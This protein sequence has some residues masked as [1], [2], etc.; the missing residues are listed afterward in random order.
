MSVPAVPRLEVAGIGKTF[1]PARVLSAA[2]LVV[3]P[4]Q[5]HALV[6]QN[7]SGKS[8]LVKI[9][10]GYHSPDGGGAIR[11]DGGPLRLPVRWAEAHAAGISVVHQEL[12]LLDH[13]TV[14]ENI[15]VGGYSRTRYL[16]RIDWS[17]QRTVAADALRS[18]RLDIDPAALVGTLSAAQRAAVAIARAI[19]DLVP[20][21]GLVILDESTRSLGREELRQFHQML[22]RIMDTGTSVL[23]VSHNLDEV[24]TF[25]DRVTVL[26]DG[27]VVGQGLVTAEQTEQ[28]IAKLMLGKDVDRV[29]ARPTGTRPASAAS[30]AGLYGPGAAGLDI[31]VGAGEVVGLTG[32]PG[33]GFENIPYLLAGA[34]PAR[35]G[36]LAVG[37]AVVNLATG[38]VAAC[39][40]AGVALVPER[41]DRDGLAM[42]LSIRDNISLPGLRGGGRRYWVGRR[43]QQRQTAE[44]IERLGIK[45]NAPMR[46]VSE[47]SGGNQQ[48]V[49][50]AKWMT[51]GPKLMI[52]HE[53]T[54]A[55]DVGARSDILTAVH[56][57][58]DAGVSVLLVSV[59]AADLAAACDRI[60]VY[61]GPDRLEEIRTDDPDT[62]LDAV[63]ATGSRPP[64]PAAS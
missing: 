8:T 44:A 43:W 35:A 53:P 27:R 36:R 22:R 10:T 26:R 2:Q 56:Q 39:I 40:R 63:Y 17:A 57:A 46:L 19:R 32:L 30:V 54:Q 58:A 51:V 25:T 20:G 6:G 37:D 23:L 18:L 11:V 34:R 55:V 60:L 49:L 28:A 14:A 61:H 50:L 29:A 4:G 16:R 59:E 5:L 12:G 7:G 42:S 31:S 1:G 45:P 3:Q 52:L 33:S 64:V 15:G 24:L 62:V 9:L 48:K 41:R 47:L 13:L 38:G 21:S